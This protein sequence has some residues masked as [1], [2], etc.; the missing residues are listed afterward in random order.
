LQ[1]TQSIPATYRFAFPE[2]LVPSARLVE[3]HL[4]SIPHT[5]VSAELGSLEYLRPR[6]TPPLLPL[7]ADVGVEDLLGAQQTRRYQPIFRGFDHAQS[8][9][10]EYD[11]LNDKKKATDVPDC[12]DFPEDDIQSQHKLVEELFDAI[13]DCSGT[14]EQPRLVN[15][16]AKKR[17]AAELDEEGDDGREWTENTYVKR[18]KT[19]K[20]VEIQFLAW[21]LLVCS[22]CPL[23]L[24]LVATP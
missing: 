5:A 11:C 10:D 16:K 1:Q 23:A 15:R 8:A 12:T 2:D 9:K 21:N 22:G 4:R 18:I 7:G 19:A 24:A 14:E 17:K 6:D 13:A 3:E 20:D